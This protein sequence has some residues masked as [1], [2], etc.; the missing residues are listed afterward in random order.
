MPA[1]CAHMA[2]EQHQGSQRTDWSA[3]AAN[4]GPKQRQF[5]AWAWQA[6]VSQHR[7]AQ[8]VPATFS[9][10][11]GA[12]CHAMQWRAAHCCFRRAVLPENPAIA[13]NW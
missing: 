2:A 12:A 5:A 13:S 3:R 6:A 9:A 1:S 7:Q 4:K 8:S 10:K 11:A